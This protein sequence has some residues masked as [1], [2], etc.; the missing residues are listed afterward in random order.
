VLSVLTSIGRK[1]DIFSILRDIE[2]SIPFITINT[3]EDHRFKCKVDTRIIGFEQ[4]KQSL[5]DKYEDIDVVNDC[6]E[7]Q[8][9][10]Q[11]AIC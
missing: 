10:H 3:F 11:I 6:V 5:E 7:S 8:N 2:K 9:S 4:I 1:Q